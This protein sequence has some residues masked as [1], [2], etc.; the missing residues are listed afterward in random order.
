MTTI[1]KYV[2]EGFRRTLAERDATERRVGAE[3]KFPLVNAADGSAVSY[4]TLNALWTYL[5]ERGWRPEVD[6]VSGQVVGARRPGEQNETV[7]SCETGYCKTEFSLAHVGNLFDL[8]KSAEELREELRPFAEANDARFL[9]YGIHPVTPPSKRLLMKKS[10]SGVWDKVF[11]S[12]RY[13]PK[14]DGDD[15]HL[16]TINAASH[17]HVSVNLDESVRAVNVLNGFS[18]AQIALT[19][20]SNIWKGALDAEFKC[21]AEKLWDWWIP[22][23]ER[24]GVPPQAFR[25]LEHYV[26]T[27]AGFRPVFVKRAGK[28]IVLNEYATFEEYFGT[29]RAKGHDAEGRLVSFVVEPSD[30][31]VHSTCYWYNARISRYYTVEN[32]VNDEQP[33]GELETIAAITLGLVSALPEATE[34]IAG[35]EWDTLRASRDVACREGLSGAVGGTPMRELSARMLDLARLGLKRRGKGEEAFLAPLEARL[36]KGRCPADDAAEIFQRGGIQALLEK[37]S[38]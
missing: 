37:R 2:Q 27:I 35:W 14:E 32:R 16:F 29:G 20:H 12:N 26:E 10:R 31:D 18:G 11:P 17:V 7:A 28:P 33:P 25:D 4:D 36:E 8:R 22:E 6:A 30:I 21:V 24:V 19:A 9:G 13:I 34:E 15:F 38:L 5:V 1:Y 3:L 23:P